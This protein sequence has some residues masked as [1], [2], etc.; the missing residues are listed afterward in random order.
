M[1]P[2][3][4]DNVLVLDERVLGQ[5]DG[6]GPLRTL[7][8]VHGNSLGHVPVPKQRVTADDVQVL[9]EVGVLVNREFRLYRWR[10][11]RGRRPFLLF[12]LLFLLLLEVGG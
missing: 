12:L 7:H 9:A 5:V 6:G 11:R 8:P 1:V 10:G 3:R 2:S 4:L